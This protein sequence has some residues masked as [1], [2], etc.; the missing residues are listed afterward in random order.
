M[1]TPWSAPKR[2]IWDCLTVTLADNADD[3]MIGKLVELAERLGLK[4]LWM[5]YLPQPQT[6][7][8]SFKQP[9]TIAKDRLMAVLSA[10]TTMLGITLLATWR[11]G[12]YCCGACRSGPWKKAR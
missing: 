2:P 11:H 4:Y 8:C 6:V 12:M 7:V 5:D 10:G 3:A 9:S 1:V